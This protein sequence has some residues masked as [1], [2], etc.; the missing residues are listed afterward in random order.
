MRL[1]MG[2]E[3]CVE[4]AIAAGMRFFAGYP[5]TPST[6][7]AEHAAER[8][9]Q[10]GGK[11]IQME[12]E[13]AGMAACIGGS[14]AG[15]KSMTATSGPG[16][17][18][19]MEN[20]GYAAMAEI[21]CVIINVMRS[22]PSTGLPT[23]PS[24]ADIMQTRWGSHGDYPIIALAPS[25]VREAYDVTVKAFN[26]SEKY[27]NPVVVLMDE[28]IGHLREG[29][30]LPEK[31]E[32]E[33]FDRKKPTCAAGDFRAYEVPEGE[34]VPPMPAFGE[35][36][37]YNITGLIH[38]DTG[39]PTN[40]NALAGK[41]CNRLMSKIEDNRDD[42]IEYEITD[43]ENCDVLV[44]TYGGTARTVTAARKHAPDAGIRMGM[45]RCITIWPFPAEALK[46]CV[47]N[48][49][50]KHVLVAELNHG[51]IS[52]EVERI[53][54]NDAKVHHIGKIDGDIL[55]PNEIL[56]KV[57]EVIKNG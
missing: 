18:L 33:V 5:I 35:G 54:K 1:L 42:I 45:F 30:N 43:A 21:P 2:N 36:Y 3:A 29:V 50:I 6:E 52:L 49:N 7:V 9:P 32:I 44:L 53:L 22:G 4:G 28:T 14:I 48:N 8:L 11:F 25:S 27:R 26:L 13:I 51:Q 17:S 57:S 55:Y 12:D 38:D 23:S 24:Q 56:K 20:I 39:F 40:S 10:V 15:L 47:R 46:A 31:L 19:K 16:Y 34:I 37:R 41:L